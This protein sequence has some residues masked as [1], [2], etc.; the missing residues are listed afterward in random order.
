MCTMLHETMTDTADPPIPTCPK[1][2]MLARRSVTTYGLRDACE[3]CGLRSWDGKELVSEA[4]LRNRHRVHE[5][6][7]RIS[8]DGS[9]IDIIAEPLGVPDTPEHEWTVKRIQKRASDLTYAYL[10]T[11][12]NL[13]G[14]ELH[15]ADQVDVPTMQRICDLAGRTSP[16]DVQAWAQA[17]GNDVQHVPPLPRPT[18]PREGPAR[19]RP[20]PC[21]SL[22]PVGRPALYKWCHGAPPGDPRIPSPQREWPGHPSAPPAIEA[23]AD[24]PHTADDLAEEDDM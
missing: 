6:F 23:P 22:D 21:G 24:D 8:E 13:P 20:C 7:N 2:G 4:V 3:P 14:R 11:T 18:P 17:R 12:L 19:N 1:C 5:A 9:W 15:M 10:A 16:S